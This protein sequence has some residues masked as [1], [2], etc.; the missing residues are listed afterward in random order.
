MGY[1]PGVG[2]RSWRRW[3]GM[4][5]DGRA[6][7]LII[8]LFILH[9]KSWANIVFGVGSVRSFERKGLDGF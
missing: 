6:I 7:I 4:I 8:I 5:M 3:Y 9:I 2:D 1:L